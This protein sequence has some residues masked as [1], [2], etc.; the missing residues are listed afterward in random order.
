MLA[1]VGPLGVKV[2][3]DPL[4]LAAGV[5]AIID[6]TMPR[7]T[8]DIAALAANARIVHVIGTTGLSDADEAAIKAAAR[9][10]TIIKAGNMSLGVNVLTALVG[11][12]PRS[13]MPIMTSRSSR[14]TTVKR[15]TRPRGRR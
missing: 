5:D 1:G 14:C 10:A 8:V 4:E 3:G 9:H 12:L 13:S 11:G 6:F 2:S 7:V 15:S